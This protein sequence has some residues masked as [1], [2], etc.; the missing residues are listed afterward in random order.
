M[1][2]AEL[3]EKR[4]HKFDKEI[5]VSCSDY[6][7][8]Y[9]SGWCWAYQDIKEILEQNGFNM[10]IEVIPPRTNSVSED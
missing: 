2:L 5:G 9:K 3:I 4:G 8:G 7:N 1:T 10:D 6:W